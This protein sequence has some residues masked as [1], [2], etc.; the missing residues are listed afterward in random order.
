VAHRPV[1]SQAFSAVGQILGDS[2]LLQKRPRFLHTH[3]QY[4]PLHVSVCHV[5]VDS[6][7]FFRAFFL[8]LFSLPFQ[9]IGICSTRYQSTPSPRSCIQ[10]PPAHNLTATTT[11]FLQIGEGENLELADKAS[12]ISV[13]GIGS[14][15]TDHPFQ[16]AVCVFPSLF[17]PDPK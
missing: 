17:E 11:P 7:F 1:Q 14:I 8:P 5:L 12:R 16:P 4:Y 3:F 9:L 15:P 2:V 13:L 6:R 10:V